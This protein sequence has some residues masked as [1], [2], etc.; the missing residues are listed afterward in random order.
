MCAWNCTHAVS[1]FQTTSL[2]SLRSSGGAKISKDMVIKG[3]EISGVTA[4]KGFF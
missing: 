4:P 3:L 1:A 2:S